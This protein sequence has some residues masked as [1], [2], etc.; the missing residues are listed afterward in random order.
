M[1]YVVFSTTEYEVLAD[2][3][4]K[5]VH[6]VKG[7]LETKK[8][9]DGER[10]YRICSL[11]RDQDVVLVGGTI[12][13]KATLDLFD[14]ACGLVDNGC[15]S[16]KI[17]IPFFGYSTME[18][19]VHAGEV[20]T[21]KTRARLLSAIPAAPFGNEVVMLDLHS[22]GIPFYFEGAVKTRHLYAKPLIL[23]EAQRLG[24]GNFILG[25]P[26]AGRAKWVESLANDLGVPAGF[27][28]KRRAD[29]GSVS[30]SGVNVIVGDANVVIYDDMIR[31]GQSILQAAQA[32]KAAGAKKISLI[33]THGLF[34]E[35]ALQRLKKGNVI[36]SVSCT[37][38]HPN[39][40]AIQD[41]FVQ[42]MSTADLF[43]DYLNG[44][45]DVSRS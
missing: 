24:G 34:S 5:A 23:K 15:R 30:I 12:H 21:A 1:S 19:A 16:L 33:T 44:A 10:Y 37:D 40:L 26:D 41:A 29:D 35:G 32:Y 17:I 42:V 9:G 27:V 38:S 11:V 7:E 14:L 8:F 18:R 20:V 22:E 45:R 36:S 2:K 4:K 13:D 28:Y 3:I 6:G 43:A 39:A 31:S 25:A